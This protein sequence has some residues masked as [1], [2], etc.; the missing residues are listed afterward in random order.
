M[1]WGSTNRRTP[2][3]L[4]VSHGCAAAAHNESLLVRSL[5]VDHLHPRLA[6]PWP[7][8]STYPAPLSALAPAELSPPPP[9]PSR[10]DFPCRPGAVSS[11]GRARSRPAKPPPPGRAPR[12][13]CRPPLVHPP[14][15]RAP[16]AP[17]ARPPGAHGAARQG[18]GACQAAARRERL[19]AAVPP[20][21]TGG[22]APRRAALGARRRVRSLG[23]ELPP[24]GPH[25]G[26]ALLGRGPPL[27][28]VRVVPGAR[29]PR[30]R[31]GVGLAHV[32]GGL[33]RWNRNPRTQPQK[34][35]NC[36]CF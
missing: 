19:A 1:S 6:L 35:N 23:L 22:G 32:L 34:C 15:G 21:A 10:S 25:R 33:H 8:G 31:P 30:P 17:A 18:G 2:H 27:P 5:A 16:R 26:A 11:R 13:A 4:S 14:G 12:A 3:G 36:V 24:V 7:G 20:G 9:H 29:G 28:D